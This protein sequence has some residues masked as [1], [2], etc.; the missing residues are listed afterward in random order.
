MLLPGADA[1]LRP[2]LEGWF[3][4]AGITPRV[5]AEFDDGALSKAFGRQGL[6]V[7]TGPAVLAAEIAAQYGVVCLATVDEL[8]EEFYALSPERRIT[9]PGVA[10]IRNAAR[11][12]LFA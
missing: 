8:A 10:A 12:A 5:V 6:G 11:H 3:R 7:F 1:A 9:H 2:R 4:A